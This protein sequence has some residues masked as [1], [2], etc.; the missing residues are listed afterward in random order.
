M[1]PGSVS[2]ILPFIVCAP[3]LP[4]H[5]MALP[6]PHTIFAFGHK[7]LRNCKDQKAKMEV[8]H[9]TSNYISLPTTMCPTTS[10][11]GGWNTNLDWTRCPH[12]Q[13]KFGTQ[14]KGVSLPDII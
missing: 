6:P 9:L 1:K 7:E 13:K 5:K 3:H 14:Y 8:N 2:F 4:G 11:T 10:L 12:L